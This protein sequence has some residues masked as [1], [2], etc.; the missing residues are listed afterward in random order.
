MFQPPKRGGDENHE[1]GTGVPE[2]RDLADGGLVIGRLSPVISVLFQ[3]GHASSWGDQRRGFQ[4]PLIHK[5][6]RFLGW[7]DF[8]DFLRHLIDAVPGGIGS[9]VGG[10]GGQPIVL[11]L[12]DLGVAA[13]LRHRATILIQRAYRPIVANLLYL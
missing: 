4:T 13:D 7:N 3:E 11:E 6:E 2:S 8:G 1:V 12:K 10:N 9:S 5:N